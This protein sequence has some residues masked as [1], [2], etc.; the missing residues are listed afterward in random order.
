MCND[1]LTRAVYGTL[2]CFSNLR[3]GFGRMDDLTHAD[4]VGGVQLAA[5]SALAV[6]GPSH[7]ATC[8]IDAR[9]GVAFVDI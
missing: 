5:M 8:S 3:Q 2:R 1:Y 6:E 4:G 9:A 7:V